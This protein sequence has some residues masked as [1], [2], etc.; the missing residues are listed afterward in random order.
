MLAGT[1]SGKTSFGP[2]WLHRE[3]LRA[4][5]SLED[6]SEGLGDFLAVTATY[7]LFKAKMLPEMLIFFVEE[8]K[9]GKYWAGDKIIE[10]TENL[11]PGGKFWAKESGDRMFARIAL[12]SADAV[13]GLEAWTAKAAW[14]DE[15]GQEKF[16]LAA[17]EAIIRRLSLY[18]GRALITTTLY[19][20]GWLKTQFYD[21]WRTGDTDYDV[22][23][24]DSTVNPIF[25]HAEYDRAQ[26]SMPTWK[27][28][29]FY[30][31][32]Y[33]RP[34]GL[35]YDS[36]DDEQ[37]IYD[38]RIMFPLGYP[39]EWHWY[40]G[41]DFGASNPAQ[42]AY[43]YDPKMGQFYVAHEFLPGSKAIPDQV[44]SLKRKLEGKAI[45]RRAGGSPTEDGWRKIYGAHQWPI[46]KPTIADVGV[47]IG[48]VYALHKRNA[49]YV[50][51]TCI[52]YLDEKQR[53]SYKLT[54]D[55]YSA[56]DEIANKSAFHLMDAER[57][58][59][60]GI[61]ADRAPRRGPRQKTFANYGGKRKKRHE[62][63]PF[64]D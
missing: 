8:L 47:G 27:F 24:F 4:L 10:L 6:L 55:G 61:Y 16:T 20:L 41:H 15:A 57:G 56:T 26:R 21:K 42:L 31:G 35:V 9:I 14:L 7:D 38:P 50:A 25:P 37:C 2:H 63:L 17:W 59:L 23:Q 36:F 34:V 5:E 54:E 19:Q 49:I 11:E 52:N 32:L 13:G 3:I 44:K 58:I 33:S 43:A 40:V 51:N 46:A 62:D 45:M 18:Q 48:Q 39:K 1:Q 53:Y 28:N 30:R 29:M 60:C 22:I 12:R 64:R